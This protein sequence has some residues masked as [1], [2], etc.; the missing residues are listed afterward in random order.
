[1]QWEVLKVEADLSDAATLD[2]ALDALIGRLPRDASNVSCP[3]AL[4]LSR[5]CA[6]SIRILRERV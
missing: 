4:T 5:V 2:A 3:H 1:M 6:P